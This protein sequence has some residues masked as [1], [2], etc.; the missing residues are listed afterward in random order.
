MYFYNDVMADT[1][2]TVTAVTADIDLFY[3]LLNQGVKQWGEGRP[4]GL[5]F[6][7]VFVC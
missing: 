7:I 4:D 5:S 2:G 6:V 1:I 3:V